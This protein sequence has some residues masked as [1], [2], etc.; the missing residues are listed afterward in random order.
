MKKIIPILSFVFISISLWAQQIDT[1]GGS[2]SINQREL[3]VILQQWTITDNAAGL[4]F[5][6]VNRGGFTTLEWFNGQ[7]NHHRMQE[8]SARNG[9]N[10]FSEGFSSFSEKIHARGRF[11][12]HK[13]LEQDRAWSDVMNTYNANPYIFG[14][15]VRGDYDSQI[16]DLDL[17]IF[18]NPV[19]R[20]TFGLAFDYKVADVSRQRD[21]RSRTYMLDYAV[22][23]SV[24]YALNPNSRVGI[25]VLYRYDKER[26][27]NLSTVQTDPNLQYFTFSGLQN[28]DGRIGGYRAFQRQFI[29]E[30]LGGSVQYNY[31]TDNMSLLIAPGFQIQNQE[32]LGDKK[33][34]PGSYNANHLYGTASLLM[35]NEQFVHQLELKAAYTDGGADEYRQSLFTERDEETGTSTEYWVTDYKYKNR[36]IIST[37]DADLS[38]KTYGLRP[39]QKEYSWSAGLDA[40]YSAFTNKYYLPESFYE[41]EKLFGGV[42]G[43]VFIL[44]RDYHRLELGASFMAG[45]ALHGALDL[46][47]DNEFSL[48]VLRP[49][50]EYHNRDTYQVGGFLKYNFPMRFVERSRMSGYARIYGEKLIAENSHDWFTIN[51]AIGLLTF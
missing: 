35:M 47:E 21:P 30:Y 50:L 46:Y 49:D 20:F 45:F 6:N 3:Q 8:G 5:S 32:T 37:T 38:W 31:H 39:N 27:P 23:P 7:G 43:S 15:N 16:F 9:L 26:M 17:N 51:I 25:N 34:S 24:V 41:S 28:V 12:F 14:S 13:E 48:Q 4:A 42:N 18:T 2:P 36:Y 29:S 1:L 33:Q 11:A 19:G 10:F 40:A 22:L 44:N